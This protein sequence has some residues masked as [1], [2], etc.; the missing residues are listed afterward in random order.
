M[1]LILKKNGIDMDSDEQL[2]RANEELLWLQQQREYPKPKEVPVKIEWRK[3]LK[4]AQK[5]VTN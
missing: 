1:I 3:I 2:A 5:E 4:Q